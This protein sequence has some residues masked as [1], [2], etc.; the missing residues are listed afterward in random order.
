MLAPVDPIVSFDAAALSDSIRRRELSC[1]EVMSAYLDQIARF[2]PV[3]NAIVSL[4][5]RDLLLAEAAERDRQLDRGAYLGRLH[6]FP[7]AV[8]DL[9][10][11]AGLPT[12]KGS[13]IFRDSVAAAD[14]PVVAKIRAAGAVFIGKTN[15]PEFGLG[16]HTFNPVFGTTVNAYD[17]SRCAGGSSG[18]AAV[19]LTMRMLPVADG[20]DFMG[21]LRNPA[22]FNNVIG[23]RPSIGRVPEAGFLAS[24]SVLGPMGRTV[25]DVAMLLSVMAG[26]D[27]HAPLSIDDD[28]AIFAQSLASDVA[29]ARIAWVGDYDGYLA[30]EPGLLELCRSSFG[31]F[32]D[33]GCVIEDALP[34]MPPAEI[35]QAYLVWR[36]FITLANS[37]ELYDNANT[38]A[39][40]KPEMIWEIEGGKR[41]TIDEVINA[42]R[43]RVRW[44]DSAMNLLERYDFIAAPT[45]QV[46]PF[47]AQL[48]WPEQIAGRPMDTYHRWMETVSP[49][50]LAGLPVIN[51]PVGFDD[52][53][54]PMGIQLIGRNHADL[55]VLRLGYA[56]EQATQWTA[57]YPPPLVLA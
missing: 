32:A 25:T 45:A 12:T 57:R 7:Y 6:G 1:V 26:A 47:D 14:S 48:R 24:P 29:G 40:L 20:S 34:S 38:R 51:L 18:G 21:S 54:L 52:R 15:V 56:Y 27:R 4:R 19:A 13:P 9:A 35:W 33:L 17:Q 5:D 49:W 39:L 11:V 50:T 22:A 16:S 53:G 36:H 44:F 8:K 43:E 55:A 37:R 46:F 28:R 31:A 23:F 30:T 3:V 41:L 10:D 42:D 2:N